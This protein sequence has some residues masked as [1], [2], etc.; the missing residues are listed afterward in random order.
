MVNDKRYKELEAEYDMC[1]RLPIVK[2]HVKMLYEARRVYTKL[3][4][5]EF[6]DQFESSLEASITNCV[7]IDDGKIYTI[8][9][10]GY[11]RERRVKRD[12]DDMLSC[13]CRL[14]EMKGVLCRHTIK[15]LREVM[16]IKE[17]PDNYILKRWT[18]KARAENVQD[19]HGHEIQADPKL[20]QASWYRSLCFAY[21][22]ISSRASENEKSFKLAM[23]N[24]ENLAKQIEDLL[25]SE[26][27]ADVDEN[28][29][30]TQP[31]PIEHP[32]NNADGNVVNAKGL[33]KRETSRGRK[34]RIKSKVEISMNKNK[35]QRRSNKNVIE[36][37]L[38]L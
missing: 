29:Q 16:Q 4:F 8:I 21:T 26:M 27:N 11:S 13:S 17:I 15:V 30:R 38:V 28:D 20:Q 19:M 2:M 34:R 32:N 12:I 10:D 23:T 25:R 7:D 33:K 3:I 14:F 37:F 18:K 9:R 36:V 5:Q 31:T 1:F 35:R 24:A 6:Q 22:R